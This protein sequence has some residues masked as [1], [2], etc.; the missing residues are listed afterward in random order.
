MYCTI[1][2]PFK[3][4]DKTLITLCYSTNG[5][6]TASEKMQQTPTVTSNAT[7]TMHQSTGIT[8][9]SS[10]I[11]TNSDNAGVC[12]K[13]ER[14][15]FLDPICLGNDSRIYFESTS[16]FT[17]L[18]EGSDLVAT[19]VQGGPLC[20]CK[21]GW[22][23]AECSMPDVVYR[24]EDFPRQYGISVAATPRRLI[25][26][27]PFNNEFDLL[28]AKI[29]ALIDIV[30]LFIIVESNYTA[31]GKP[32]DCA[33]LNRLNSGFLSQYHSKQILYVP[34]YY[35]P[36]LA[37]ANGWIIDA[38]L[39]NQIAEEGLNRIYDLRDDDVIV[40]QDA[41]ELPLPETLMFLKVLFVIS[42]STYLFTMMC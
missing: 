36:T 19:R 16:N 17:C 40:I 22:H 35:F 24:S 41:D 39:R 15:S 21:P 29:M 38:L 20:V 3:N 25:Y 23:G 27:M 18:L 6:Y 7:L 10:K 13:Y 2:L 12:T 9:Y 11:P 14:I 42:F 4:D 33:L 34:L 30:D 28:E 31:A 5:Q 26:A 37:Y 1:L 8:T 32:K